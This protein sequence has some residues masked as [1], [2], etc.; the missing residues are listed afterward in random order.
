M[1]FLRL[2]CSFA[3]LYVGFTAP[4]SAEVLV[5]SDDGTV[6]RSHQPGVA[7]FGERSAHPPVRAPVAA[8]AAKRRTVI[9]EL[10]RMRA[11]GALE[12]APYAGL[13]KEYESAKKLVRRLPGRRRIEMHGAVRLLEKM[14]AQGSMTVSRLEPLWVTLRANRKWWTSGPLLAAG[15]RVQVGDSE[16]VWQYVPGQGL[17]LHPLANFGKLNGLWQ[18]KNYDDRLAQLLDELLPIAAVRGDGLAW[19]YYFDY[20]GGRGP[21]VSGLAQGTALQA[22]ARAAIRLGRKDEI[23][24]IARQ[25]LRLFQVRPPAGVR[26]QVSGGAH[27]LIYSFNSKLRVLNA[28]AQALVGLND[29]GAY[30]NDDAARALFADGDRAMQVELPRYDTGFWS[31]YSLQRES[32]LSYH[33]LVTGFLGTLCE[34]TG[35]PVYCETGDRFGS[36][37]HEPP[38]LEIVSER[39]RGG[40]V[41]PLRFRVSKISRVLVRV[42]KGDRLVYSRSALMSG[43]ARSFAWAVPR[44]K[45]E[46]AVRVTATDLA[47]NTSSVKETVE[48]LKPKKRT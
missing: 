13:R 35:T 48:V 40:T 43:G 6:S 10:K 22:L 8:A 32:D 44:K 25:G 3:A 42:A 30:A 26:V 17:H 34:R 31:K 27:Y 45:G 37:L 19:E 9:G 14:A 24:P 15:R 39:V 23:L 4:V 29:F 5:L 11:A 1:R 20:G 2:L 18:G 36:Y 46:Y 33:R 47:G 16:L 12:Q 7:A 21:W 41:A 38:V 28:F